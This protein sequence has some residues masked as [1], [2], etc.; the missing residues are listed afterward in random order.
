MASKLFGDLFSYKNEKDK[1]EKEKITL[2]EKD[3]QSPL[4]I[5]DAISSNILKLSY[6]ME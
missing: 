2:R 5:D 6:G 3:S 4:I 1:S